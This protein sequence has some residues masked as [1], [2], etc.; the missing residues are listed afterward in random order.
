ME[1]RMSVGHFAITVQSDGLG[2]WRA[3]LIDDDGRRMPVGAFDSLELATVAAER[4]AEIATGLIQTLE[5]KRQRT[6]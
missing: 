5:R 1:H 2:Q 4:N 6:V 3:S